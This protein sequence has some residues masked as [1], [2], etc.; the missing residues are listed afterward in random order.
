M[1]DNPAIARQEQENDRLAAEHE[2]LA[3]ECLC[4]AI[5]MVRCQAE[6]ADK[7]RTADAVPKQDKSIK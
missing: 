1:I 5:G 6:E 2:R 3:E 4:L 7:K